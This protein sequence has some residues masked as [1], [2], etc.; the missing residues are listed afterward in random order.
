MSH[1]NYRLVKRLDGG[2]GL[3]EVYYNAKGEP[4]AMTD[5]P[6]FYADA[7]GGPQ[8]IIDALEMALSDAKNRGLFEEPE[9]GKW[10]QPDTQ[11]GDD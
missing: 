7:E 10:A 4:W 1:W 5:N 3:H 11:L 8:E 2:Y 9:T 6:I